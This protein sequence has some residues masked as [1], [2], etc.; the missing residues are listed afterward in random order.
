MSRAPASAASPMSD[1]ALATV[2]DA[3][4]KTGATCAAQTLTF[5]YSTMRA[6]PAWEEGAAAQRA[7]PRCRSRRH[8]REVVPQRHVLGEI[9]L[10]DS[11]LDLVLPVFYAADVAIDDAGMVLF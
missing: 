7:L 1:T 10:R 3:S 4:R 5:G 8:G 2:F 9:L 11:P 6:A